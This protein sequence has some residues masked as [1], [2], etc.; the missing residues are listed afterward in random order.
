MSYGQ[1]LAKVSCCAMWTRVLA[2]TLVG[3]EFV[4]ALLGCQTS[5]QETTQQSD[6]GVVPGCPDT[7]LMVDLSGTR[8]AGD[9]TCSYGKEVCKCEVCAPVRTCRCLDGRFGCNSELQQGIVSRK[10]SAGCH[11]DEYMTPKGCLSCSAASFTLNT[12]LSSASRNCNSDLDCSLVEFAYCGVTCTVALAL[13][14]TATFKSAAQTASNEQCGSNIMGCSFS[15]QC[16]NASGVK[17]AA[18]QCQVSQ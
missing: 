17:C 5:N 2:T 6:V 10:C 12:I 4:V 14:A 3:M 18:H 16:A 15:G 8:C 9:N 7:G 11:A 13:E 1:R